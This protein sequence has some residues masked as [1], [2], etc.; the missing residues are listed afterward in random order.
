M[1]RITYHTG[2]FDLHDLSYGAENELFAVNTLFSCISKFSSMI[3]TLLA[4]LFISE[5]EP[6]DVAKWHG[7][8]D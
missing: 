2:I 4:T 3:L 7:T 1:P 6:E 8:K 5:L